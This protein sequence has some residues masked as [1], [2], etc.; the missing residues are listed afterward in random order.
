MYKLLYYVFNLV[1]LIFDGRLWN[2]YF[3]LKRGGFS[4]IR[5]YV[6]CKGSLRCLNEM[7]WFKRSYGKEN[8]VNFEERNGI[9]VCYS[10]NIEVED[11][12]CFVVKVWE[13]SEDKKWVI[14]YYY[15]YY[16]CEFVKK[17]C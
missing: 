2:L 1:L 15:N 10:C 6:L 13:V 12:L 9:K 17:M 8:R 3:N 5:R 11:V 14:V 7:C 4:G 16:I